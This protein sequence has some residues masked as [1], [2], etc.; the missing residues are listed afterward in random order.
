MHLLTLDELKKVFPRVEEE[1]MRL[2]HFLKRREP[3]GL[4]ELVNGIHRELFDKADCIS[5][6]NCCKLMVP[7]LS[8][9]DIAGI[10]GRLGLSEQDFRTRWYLT[11]N[12]ALSSLT[13]AALFMTTGLKCAAN[14]PLLIRTKLCPGF[15]IWSGTVKS[16]Q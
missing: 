13:K 15:S 12:P 14:I 4:D 1:N 3:G 9:D 16:A 10:S 7:A 2:R 5:C 8:P 11:R 6:S